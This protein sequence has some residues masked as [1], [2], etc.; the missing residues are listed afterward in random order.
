MEQTEDLDDTRKIWTKKKVGLKALERCQGR[1][2]LRC[3]HPEKR[4]A[5][6]D[7]PNVLGA[8]FPLRALARNE[9]GEASGILAIL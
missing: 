5:P 1:Q 6:R 4:G 7:Q 3:K 2:N 8:S 9:S